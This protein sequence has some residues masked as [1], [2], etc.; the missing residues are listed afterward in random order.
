RRSS[1]L[2]LGGGLADS[3]Q[4]WLFAPVRGRRIERAEW[5]RMRA[6]LYE[7]NSR[8]A[9]LRQQ[10][11]AETTDREDLLNIVSHELRTPLTVLGGYTR[12][13]LS[14]PVGPLTDEQRCFLEECRRSCQRLNEFVDRL[15][16]SSRDRLQGHS[17]VVK[18]GSVEPT[19]RGVVKFLRPLLEEN[20]VLPGLELDPDLPQA[21]FDCAGV[22]QVLTN[23]IENAIRY[24]DG[25][26]EV[27]IEA[28]A[29][30]TASGAAIEVSVS[31]RGPGIAEGERDRLFEPYFRGNR[32]NQAAGLG[33][34][35]SICKRI[36][37]A[38]GGSIYVSNRPGGGSRF[39]FTVPVA[40]TARSRGAENA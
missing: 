8:V 38:H 12:L 13:L 6:A 2:G 28:T 37:E 3:E 25:P 14:D 20:H 1:D 40:D 39:A 35:L 7:A 23:L 21:L 33:L 9:A 11:E 27:S 22:E 26:G 15:L 5:R 36:V 29:V 17:L 31:D 19:I 10:L 18:E 32:G 30:Q 4:I 34:G 24:T 16:C